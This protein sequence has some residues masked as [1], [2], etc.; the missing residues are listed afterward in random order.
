M[1]PSR[2]GCFQSLMPPKDQACL[3][4][5]LACGQVPISSRVLAQANKHRS[6]LPSWAQTQPGL[7]GGLLPRAL[8]GRWPKGCPCSR[9]KGNPDPGRPG[10]PHTVRLLK[11]S[12]GQRLQ[13]ASAVG[14]RRGS[15]G[16]TVAPRELARRVLTL[17][18]AFENSTDPCTTRCSHHAFLSHG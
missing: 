4:R 11:D 13:E 18:A 12:G 9:G 6:V 15:S 3:P 16:G 10:L 5:N 2:P 7:L 8:P 17:G 1:T 14:G